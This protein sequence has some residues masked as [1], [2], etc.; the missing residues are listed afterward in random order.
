MARRYLQIEL[1]S[2]MILQIYR[3][4]G[5]RNAFCIALMISPLGRGF[6]RDFTVYIIN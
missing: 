4:Y 2:T 1:T 6:L 5:Y 3:L